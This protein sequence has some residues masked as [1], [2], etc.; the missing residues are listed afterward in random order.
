MASNDTSG[1]LG[2]WQSKLDAVIGG[3]HDP[4]R[5]TTE[6]NRTRSEVLAELPVTVPETTRQKMEGVRGATVD[7]GK[8]VKDAF[9]R[10]KEESKPLEPNA[11]GSVKHASAFDDSKLLR[12]EQDMA[13]RFA[14]K[15]AMPSKS[16]RPSRVAEAQTAQVTDFCR[17]NE[18]F[19]K[20]DF[21][22]AMAE[23]AFASEVEQ[24]RLFALLNRG[25][26]YK[27]LKLYA[28]AIACYQ[29]V[30]DAAGLDTPEGRLVH[31]YALN[32]LGAACQDDGRVEQALQHFSSAVALNPKCHL[33]LKNRGNLHL[34]YS[35][36]LAA[37]G[38]TPALV[39]PQHELALGQLV[40][41][42]E[43]DW[44]L[45]VVFAIA[46][47][48]LVRVDTCI[49]SSNEEPSDRL[50]RNV[51]YHFTSNLTHATSAHV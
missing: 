38:D 50:F 41:A 8:E 29:D 3:D 45:P 19:A 26:A 40:K 6:L 10:R 16:I 22:R 37:N 5:D 13:K 33:A 14:D 4:R 44:Q 43:Q 12:M 24:L 49:T 15:V 23:F 11:R 39:P 46:N 32:N 27:G 47:D 2:F 30:L 1:N 18:L 28:E 20:R 9:R 35:E 21:R 31:S 36:R 25:N 48:V 17:G 34:A 51:T 42:M 7:Q